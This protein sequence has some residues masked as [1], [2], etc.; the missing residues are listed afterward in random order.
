MGS[1]FDV[2]FKLCVVKADESDLQRATSKAWK[3]YA[4]EKAYAETRLSGRL[5]GEDSHNT[6]NPFASEGAGADASDA[7]LWFRVRAD[8]LYYASHYVSEIADPYDKESIINRMKFIYKTKLQPM[9]EYE[10]GAKI[11]IVEANT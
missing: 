9:I 7:R 2:I 1:Q 4:Q 10:L 11:G 3:Q 5:N 6:V 8:T